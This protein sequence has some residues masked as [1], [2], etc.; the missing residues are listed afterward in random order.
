[1]ILLYTGKTGDGKTHHII[2]NELLPAL[3][4]GRRVYT[5]ID[6]LNLRAIAAFMDVPYDIIMRQVTICTGNE[7]RTLCQLHM[8]NSGDIDNEG[9]EL[10]PKSLVIVDE[11]QMIWASSDWAKFSNR[12][13]F[14][15]LL[16]YHRH[17]GLDFIL[18]TQASK[19]LDVSVSRTANE[20]CQVER[21]HYLGK[22][23]ARNYAV[24]HRRAIGAPIDY[25]TN[26]VFLSDIFHLYRCSFVPESARVGRLP[27]QAKLALAAAAI[28]L[29]VVI[30]KARHNR[31]ISKIQ[32]SNHAQ[33]IGFVS[34]P[35]NYNVA[36]S[37]FLQPVGVAAVQQLEVL[38]QV[39][40][41]RDSISTVANGDGVTVWSTPQQGEGLAGQWVRMADG[42]EMWVNAEK[43]GDR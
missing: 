37:T 8:L 17:F 25:T 12:R 41:L 28:L 19:N 30:P 13:A 23:G 18:I 10:E 32:F 35:A 5:N 1:M 16:E 11:A 40:S 2:R 39:P 15:S 21:R 31:F 4:Q 3:R 22:L 6:G 27:W 26:H 29:F 42:S 7:I 34:R 14:M 33:K 36:V 9:L 24:H 43:R 38:L 20:V